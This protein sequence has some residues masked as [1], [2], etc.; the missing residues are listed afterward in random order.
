[1]S[2]DFC[3]C[4]SDAWYSLEATG[5]GASFQNGIVKQ[6]RRI[7]ANM[8]RTMLS[9]VNLNLEYWSHVIRHAIYI[10][11]V[12]RTNLPKYITLFQVF[13][14]RRPDLTHIRVFSS[15]VTI[16]Q[17]RVRCYKLDTDHT[18]S[19]I[20][21]GFSSTNRL[22]WFEDSASGELKSARHAIFDEA[23]YSANNRP[24]Y[25]KQLMELAEEHLS[26]PSTPN[27][28]PSLSIYLIPDTNYS[29]SHAI[30]PP[31]DTPIISIPPPS[32]MHNPTDTHINITSISPP[33]SHFST[34]KTPLV[35]P[36][37]ILDDED[38]NPTVN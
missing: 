29:P 9:V 7:L 37:I 28:P 35:I 23:H 5:D 34:T 32:D 18:T 6:P 2:A 20:F 3:Q 33:V 19:G 31:D 27:L 36:H 21:L 30:A 24:P 16:K 4:I 17:A 8:M 22:I 13:T 26:T 14:N 12:F 38:N 11:I 25:A 1:M 10:K 15:Y